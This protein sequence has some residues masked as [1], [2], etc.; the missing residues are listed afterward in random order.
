MIRALYVHAPA[1]FQ[2]LLHSYITSRNLRSSD[3]GLLVV[4]C[5][6]LKTKAFEF[7]DP[8]LWNS[9]PLD[10]RSVDFVDAFQKQLKIYLNMLLFG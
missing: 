3:H 1:N 8:L 10:L 9:L 6:R 4:P 5:S 2:E 7:V